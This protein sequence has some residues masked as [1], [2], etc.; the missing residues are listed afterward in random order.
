MTRLVLIF[1]LFGFLDEPTGH[2]LSTAGANVAKLSGVSTHLEVAAEGHSTK[3]ETL[4]FFVGEVHPNQHM[5]LHAPGEQSDWP[6][7]VHCLTADSSGGSE[8]SVKATFEGVYK[9]VRFDSLEPGNKGAK[10]SFPDNHSDFVRY[11]AS[12]KIQ[13]GIVLCTDQQG[14]FGKLLP[15]Q[16]KRPSSF[17]EQAEA[18]AYLAMW[19]KDFK[20]AYGKEYS[21]SEDPIGPPRT[22]LDAK[23]LVAVEIAGTDKVLHLS[24]FE[25]RSIAA[26]AYT[27]FLLDIYV[28]KKLLQ[29]SRITVDTGVLG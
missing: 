15:V 10:L 18:E 5:Y 20:K 24:R 6:G 7:A 4:R 29:Q 27:T 8:S 22:I 21:D 23:P 12:G 13:A 28:N 14:A 16:E 19:K 26:H 25:T 17:S 2:H 1:T 11:K 9:K 3:T